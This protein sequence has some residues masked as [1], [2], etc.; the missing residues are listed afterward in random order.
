MLLVQAI[1]PASPAELPAALELIFTQ[2]VTATL[3][4]RT[5]TMGLFLAVNTS[6]LNA[7][8]L[9]M[10]ALLLLPTASPAKAPISG[11]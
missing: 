10:A 6:V 3:L 2:I 1:Q 4:A 8:Q 9:A 11:K 7:V 5:A